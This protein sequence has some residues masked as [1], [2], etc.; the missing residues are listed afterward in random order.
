MKRV[1]RGTVSRDV[2]D[3]LME[4]PQARR[5]EVIKA[6]SRHNKR[7]VSSI[8]YKRMNGTVIP[9][10]FGQVASKNGSHRATG[11][12]ILTTT[13][14]REPLMLFLTVPDEGYQVKLMDLRKRVIGT[15]RLTT[16]GFNFVPNNAKK[17]GKTP[18]LKYSRAVQLFACGLLGE[19]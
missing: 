18:F 11:K 3:Y 17:I 16:Y 19:E 10:N 13:T 5:G 12:V 2:D 9:R 7:S 8:Y 1:T 14:Q 15:L 4:H 6:L